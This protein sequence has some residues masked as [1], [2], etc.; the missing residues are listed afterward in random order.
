MLDAASVFAAE[1]GID[2]GNTEKILEAGVIG[3]AA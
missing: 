2:H 1:T 3:T